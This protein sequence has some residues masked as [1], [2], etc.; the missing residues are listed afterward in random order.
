MAQKYARLEGNVVQ[1]T[2][3]PPDGFKLSDCFH[4]DVAAMFV[5]CPQEVTPGYTLDGKTWKPPVSQ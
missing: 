1:E 2:F 3:T 5:T 4:A